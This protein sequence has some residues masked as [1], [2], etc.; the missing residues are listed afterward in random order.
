MAFKIMEQG[1]KPNLIWQTFICDTDDDVANLPPNAPAGSRA[2]VAKNGNLYLLD[3]QGNWNPMPSNGGGGGGGSDV[4]INPIITGE[5]ERLNGIEV[6]GTKYANPREVVIIKSGT[7][8]DITSITYDQIQ[9]VYDEGALP[10]LSSGLTMYYPLS[11]AQTGTAGLYT[12]VSSQ[13]YNTE[14]TYWQVKM[15]YG[16][17]RWSYKNVKSINTLELYYGVSEI[18]ADDIYALY[19]GTLIPYMW[20]SDTGTYILGTCIDGNSQLAFDLISLTNDKF[21]RYKYYFGDADPW[22]KLELPLSSLAIF[23]C[24]PNT[25]AFN[26]IV[27]HALA[28]RLLVIFDSSDSRYYYGGNVEMLN[29]DPIAVRFYTID[30]GQK[31]VWYVDSNDN[32]VQ[33]TITPDSSIYFVEPNDTTFMGIVGAVS[34]GKLPVIND[35]AN[36]RCYYVSG[37]QMVSGTPVAIVFTTLDGA[38]TWTVDYQD[39]WTST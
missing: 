22:S 21:I 30:G 15:E 2:I 19:A 31:T 20:D 13:Y 36:G 8:Q 24:E 6:D 25:T 37:Y 4:I 16:Q 26:D 7:N 12:F 33:D 34:D 10:L 17:T 3:T 35:I 14:L 39:N 32:W 38:H 11:S 23:Y 27:Q 1:R 18:T 9:E 29:G 28:G 5:E